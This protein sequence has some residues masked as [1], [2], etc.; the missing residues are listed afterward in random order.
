LFM[1]GWALP[2]GEISCGKPILPLVPYPCS[3][4]FS[5]LSNM[6]CSPTPYEKSSSLTLLTNIL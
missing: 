3:Y 2:F 6:Y 1:Q 4:F 5:L